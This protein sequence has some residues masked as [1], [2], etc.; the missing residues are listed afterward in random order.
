M[1][2]G[3]RR[4]SPSLAICARARVFYPPLGDL[5]NQFLSPVLTT[6]CEQISSRSLEI[7][8]RGVPTFLQRHVDEY[9]FFLLT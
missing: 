2:F 6:C 4:L 1:V 9:M 3:F 7:E 5:L 8:E